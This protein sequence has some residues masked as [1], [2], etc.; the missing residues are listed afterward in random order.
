M[1]EVS[2]P[3][4]SPL[5]NVA[6]IVIDV[7][8]AF[9]E[10]DFWGPRNNPLCDENITDLITHWVTSGAPLVYVR[11]DSS[12]SGSPLAPGSHGHAFKDYLVAL[13][14]VLITKSVNS[15]FLGEPDLDVWLTERGITSVVICGIT[16]NHCCETTARFSGNLGYRTYFVIDATHTFDRPDMNGDMIS[17]DEIS[18]VTASNLQDEF[19]EVVLTAELLRRFPI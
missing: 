18:R 3:D 11:H 7:Q 14:D 19:A 9:D 10:S 5:N 8:K 17:A 1:L 4:S 12:E 2:M 13:P 16:T 15:A 6:L